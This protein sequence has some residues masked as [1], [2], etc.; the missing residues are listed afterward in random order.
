MVSKANTCV[1]LPPANC[2]LPGTNH[3]GHFVL[4]RDLLRSLSK[5]PKRV[6]VLASKGH[7]FAKMELEDLHFRNRAYNSRESYGNSKLANILFAKELTA[8]A[9][10]T[11]T[12]VSLHPG[13]INT[14]LDRH[15]PSWGRFIFRTLVAIP[16]VLYLAIGEPAMKNMAQ[17]AAT[18]I[19]AALSDE[20]KGG[21][22]CADCAVAPT[23]TKEAE[24]EELQKKLWQVT[25]E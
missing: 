1:L 10:G 11:Y 25:E 12:A 16:G 2:F 21:E 4:T 24:D 7:M 22:Y 23:I 18:T 8:R 9:N 15:L 20:I 19:W 14:N 5:P 6:V 17:G 3:F 13:G